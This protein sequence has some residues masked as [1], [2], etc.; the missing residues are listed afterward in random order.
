MPTLTDDVSHATPSGAGAVL[1]RVEASRPDWVLGL[2]NLPS[3]HRVA[4]TVGSDPAGDTDVQL[5]L[6]G[7]D[8]IAVVPGRRPEAHAT[9]LVPAPLRE[10]HPRWF[11]ALLLVAERV[12]DPRF[13]PVRMMLKDELA[14]LARTPLSSDGR[15][16]S[17]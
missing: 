17:R 6:R 12:Y 10:E 1:V 7:Y 4:V 8:L 15:S 3:P 13:G 14:A 11:A 5:Q 9:L 2:P 16:T